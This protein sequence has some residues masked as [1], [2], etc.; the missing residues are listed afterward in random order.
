MEFC[1]ECL[2]KYLSIS[3]NKRL[4]KQSFQYVTDHPG[5][6]FTEVKR[7][8]EISNGQTSYHLQVLEREEFVRSVREGTQKRFFAKNSRFPL[9]RYPHANTLNKTQK[10]II[11][12]LYTR[13]YMTQAQLSKMINITPQSVSY[14]ISELERL[15]MIK[16]EQ[17]GFRKFCSLEDHYL[18]HINSPHNK[19]SF[20]RPCPHCH[21]E[22]PIT[23]IYCSNCG[24]KVS[25][26]NEN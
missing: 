18:S 26:L 10:K 20:V 8:I 5:A 15:G 19:E 17:Q 2:S 22:L 1:K 16:I 13:P 7:A 4:F 24:Y 14:N 21:L 9:R 25:W 23:F 11:D 12:I 3:I 6:S